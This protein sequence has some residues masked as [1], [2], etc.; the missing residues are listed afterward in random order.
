MAPDQ[1][2]PTPCYKET[3]MIWENVSIQLNYQKS[4]NNRIRW[5]SNTGSKE[6]FVMQAYQLN[7]A[8]Y[9]NL[10]YYFWIPWAPYK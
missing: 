6:A 9:K 4:R 7:K 1:L 2:S 3:I 10:L 5:L 8:T